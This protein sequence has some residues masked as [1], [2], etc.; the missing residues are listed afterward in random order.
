MSDILLVTALLDKCKEIHKGKM[1]RRFQACCPA[2]NDTTPSLAVALTNDDRILFHCWA[3]CGGAD[4]VSALGIPWS[5][6]MPEN[7]KFTRMES[8][9]GQK[10]KK[11][12][13]VDDWFIGIAKS[14][15][16]NGRRLSETEKKQ[17]IEAYLKLLPPSC[18]ERG[19][20]LA[21]VSSQIFLC[22]SFSL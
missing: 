12:A 17:E 9:F 3:G 19:Q 1:A 2:H 4:V 14:D 6:V 11:V 13:T 10:P 8:V 21:G 5:E 18:L 7:D 22:F 16:S 20:V 15:R